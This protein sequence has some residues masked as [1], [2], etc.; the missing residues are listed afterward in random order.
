S[1]HALHHASGRGFPAMSG[2]SGDSNHYASGNGC[3]PCLFFVFQARQDHWSTVSL[4]TRHSQVHRVERWQVHVS[5]L[6]LRP[7]S[8]GWN[9]VRRPDE[10]KATTARRFTTTTSRKGVHGTDRE[11]TE[12]RNRAAEDL[13]HS[14]S[15]PQTASVEVYTIAV[16]EAIP[17]FENAFPSLEQLERHERDTIFKDYV[18]KVNLISSYYCGRKYWG[19]CKTKTMCSTATCY[20][21]EVSFD[22]YYPGATEN[23]GAFQSSLRSHA[24]DHVAIFFP[25]FNRARITETEFHAL[26]ALIMTDHDLAISER[27]HQLLDGIR[28]EIFEDLQSYYQN[29]IA[30]RDFSTRLGN[31]ITLN[32]AVQECCAIF[33]VYFGF[34]SSIFDNYMVNRSMEEL[35][36][37]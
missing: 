19:D 12:E 2:L 4:Q 36:L 30:L 35:L 6:S 33:R 37:G 29:E 34:Y 24:N 32:H 8:L 26:A 17:F 28:A 5:S 21:S 27:A 16:V 11:E 14:P 10:N 18:A 15:A 3:L 23:K 13:W 20:D 7:M 9:G 31:L 22:F 1:L 25:I